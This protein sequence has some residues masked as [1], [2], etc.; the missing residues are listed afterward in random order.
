MALRDESAHDG[1]GDWADE[2]GGR[3]H[4]H[5]DSAVHGA[6]EVGERPADD[7]Q[8]SAAEDAA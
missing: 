1:A 4:G 7:C 8:W 5:G 6:P 2:R 3:K